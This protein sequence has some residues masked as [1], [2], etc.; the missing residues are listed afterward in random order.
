MKVIDKSELAETKHTQ[1]ANSFK[2][3][4]KIRTNLNIKLF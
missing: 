4:L 2:Y 3:K 1:N